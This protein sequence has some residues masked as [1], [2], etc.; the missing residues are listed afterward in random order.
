MKD[1]IVAYY[2][3]ARVNAQEDAAQFAADDADFS[4]DSGNWKDSNI[5]MD[6]FSAIPTLG[7]VR[8]TPQ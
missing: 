6:V 5:I 3:V 8:S 2:P 7:S 4:E 1:Q